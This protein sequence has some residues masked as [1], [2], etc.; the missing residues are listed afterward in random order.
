MEGGMHEKMDGN[1]DE[2]VGMTD[3][4][5]VGRRN[6]RLDGREDNEKKRRRRRKKKNR[7][8]EIMR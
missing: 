1:E 4:V 3:M 8:I 5:R 6:E 2:D 7:K